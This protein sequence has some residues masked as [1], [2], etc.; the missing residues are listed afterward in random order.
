M[1]ARPSL[2]IQKCMPNQSLIIGH[3]FKDYSGI[4][5]LPFELSMSFRQTILPTPVH[6]ISWAKHTWKSLIDVGLQKP[7]RVFSIGGSEVCGA[8]HLHNCY[9]KALD[10]HDSR[11]LTHGQVVINWIRRYIVCQHT[12][13]GGHL[14]IDAMLKFS[15]GL[16]PLLKEPIILHHLRRDVLQ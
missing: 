6:T 16:P 9:G 11:T 14:L 8:K 5:F 1:A 7:S 4:I 10:T 15:G 2:C 12:Q 13:S 3:R